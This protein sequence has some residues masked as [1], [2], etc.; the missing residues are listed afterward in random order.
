MIYTIRMNGKPIKT[1]SD[2]GDAKE[3]L[4]WLLTQQQLESEREKLI[5][6]ALAK[7]DFNE[8]KTIINHIM[9]KR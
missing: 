2:K 8:A 1:F 6:A 3:F 9:E 7:S 4:Q 5:E